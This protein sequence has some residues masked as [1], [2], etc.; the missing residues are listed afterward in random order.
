MISDATS[1]RKT[2]MN[3]QFEKMNEFYKRTL[4]TKEQQKKAQSNWQ[5]Y[6]GQIIDTVCRETIN[7]TGWR[8]SKA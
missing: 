5:N 6:K 3:I 2:K 8:L 1:H 4:Y 7:R